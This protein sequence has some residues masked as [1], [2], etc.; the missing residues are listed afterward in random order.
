MSREAFEKWALAE[1]FNIDR[2]PDVPKYADY[3]RTTTR[4]AWDR[5]MGC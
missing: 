2:D 5:W 1:G 3:H 4:W